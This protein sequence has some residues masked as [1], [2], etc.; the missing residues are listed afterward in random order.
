MISSELT[1]SVS[2]YNEDGSINLGW[3]KFPLYDL[4]IE[5]ARFMKLKAFQRY[6]TKKWDYYYVF[7][8]E[9]FFS[10]T[11]ADLGYAGMAFA[12]FYDY[13]TNNITEDT[14]VIP[15]AGGFKMARNSGGG[16]TYFEN[17]RFKALFDVD[18]NSRHVI[19]DWPS[20]NG[21]QG[22]SADFRLL[23]CKDLESICVVTPIEIKKMNYTHKICCMEAEGHIKWGDTEKEFK[24]G[25]DLGGLDW[26]RGFLA[27][28]TFWNWS[29]SSAYQ[30]GHKVGLNLCF[31]LND[32]R[33][34]ENAFFIDNKCFKVDTVKFEYDVN[35]RMKPWSITSSDGRVNLTFQPDKERI[36][37]TDIKLV[38]SEV[39]QMFGHYSGELTLDD[40]SKFAVSHIRG[41]IE[42]HHATW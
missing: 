13:S 38:K 16:R 37:K 41:A 29:C 15:F 3:S 21:G 18:E 27:T 6:R 24:P 23:Q 22:V 30:D 11:L 8:D 4:N 9:F 10:I 2:L 42:D 40:G 33:D 7:S 35:D 20:F 32:T 26:S 14:L 1:E 36:A 39:H 31:G 25:R 34:T 5:K 12:Y 28:N 19:L 17:K